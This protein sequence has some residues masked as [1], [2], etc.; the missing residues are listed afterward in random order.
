M[1]MVAL[2][3]GFEIGSKGALRTGDERLREGLNGI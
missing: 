3:I 2:L 1:K